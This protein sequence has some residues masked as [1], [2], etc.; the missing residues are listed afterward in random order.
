MAAF[1][2]A[3]KPMLAACRAAARGIPGGAVRR[4]SSRLPSWLPES[5]SAISAGGRRKAPMAAMQPARS[6]AESCVTRQ[7][8]TSAG[9]ITFLPPLPPLREL[10]GAGRIAGRVSRQPAGKAP[11]GEGAGDRQQQA[12]RRLAAGGGP[13]RTAQRNERQAQR[14]AGHQAGARRQRPG[15][16]MMLG[17]VALEIAVV[18]PEEPA[19]A[20]PW[21]GAAQGV[22]KTRL[23]PVEQQGAGLPQAARQ[24]DVL[25][26]GGMKELVEAARGC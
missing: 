10:G 18:D 11:S 7:T 16:A 17:Q 2:P 20:Q 15:G 8:A 22:A 21:D 19:V 9:T 25:E 4:T 24:V 26:P 5:T 23:R 14:Q 6:G 1:M 3:A 13:A 12:G